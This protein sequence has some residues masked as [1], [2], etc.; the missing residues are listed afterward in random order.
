LTALIKSTDAAGF[1]RSRRWGRTLLVGG[2]VAGSVLLLAVATFVYRGFQQRLI[3]GPGHR[4]DHLLLMSFNPSLV[5]YSDAQAQQFF[6]QIAERARLVP[7]VKS[8]ALA[9]SV[10][11]DGARPVTIA[12]EGFQFPEGKES[13]TVPGAIVDEYYFDTM[14][15]SIV[16][17]RGVRSTDSVDA[18]KVAVVN[19]V[20]AR[21]YWPGQN[22]VGKRFRLD[23]K[24][25]SW[26]KVVGLAKTSKYLF[27]MEPPR[28]FVYLPYRQRPQQRMTLVT[29]SVG[30]PSSLVTPLREVVRSLD[31]NQ[32][33]FNI[34]TMEEFYRMRTVV[35]L[36]VV[37]GFILA[38]GLMGL[39]LAIVGLY[40]LVEYAVTRRTKEIGIRMAIGATRATVL[41]MVLRQGMA[42]AVAGLSVGLLASLGASRAMAAV[43]PGGPGGDGR[44]DVVAFPLV[45]A[46]VLAVTLLA[47]YVPA[48]HA[49][50]INPNEALRNE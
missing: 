18:P 38:M 6:E 33:I 4:T 47:A 5:R 37:S 42:L 23:N 26:V 34:R 30:D 1:G 35:T 12:P 22:P 27:I 40:G 32:P 46:I 24:D 7:G 44:T 8:A 14:G 20:L 28:E 48:R 49:A 31:A 39:V 41:R 17:G 15:L 29:E 50:R 13:T 3:A 19:E 11:M 2:Q 25:G 16:E 36:K 10:P 43:F 9:S 21:H 45:A